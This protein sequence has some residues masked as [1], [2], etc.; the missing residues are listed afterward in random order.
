MREVG[1]ALAF[2]VKRS[3]NFCGVVGS[4]VLLYQSGSR[5]GQIHLSAASVMAGQEQRYAL[6]R[7]RYPEPLRRLLDASLPLQPADRAEAEQGFLD[8]L[9][10]MSRLEAS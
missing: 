5:G 1:K 8:G 10:L 3:E 2:L 6:H 7:D 9:S 4:D